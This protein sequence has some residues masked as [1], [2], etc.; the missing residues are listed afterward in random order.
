MQMFGY[1]IQGDIIQK[2]EAQIEAEKDVFPPKELRFKALEL[3]PF[4]NVKVVILGQ[5]PYHGKGQAHGLSFSVPQGVKRPPSLRN[6]YKEIEQEFSG[7]MPIHG[8][9]SPWATQG[10]LLLNAVLSVASGKPTS[11]AKLGWEEV[12]DALILQVSESCEN[13]VFLLWGAYAQ[14][15]EKLIDQNK[16]L[17]LKTTHPSPFSAHKGFLGCGHFKLANAYLEKHY[18]KPINWLLK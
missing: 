4:K 12:T 10:V 6:I 18:Q 17:V 16:H 14:K 15:K 9:L 13:V 1:Q 5:D 7:E 11:H 8:D 3:T 2:I